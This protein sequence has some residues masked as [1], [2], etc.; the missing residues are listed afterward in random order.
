MRT[1]PIEVDGSRVTGGRERT[2]R[3]NQAALAESD[4]IGERLTRSRCQMEDHGMETRT[5]PD[6]VEV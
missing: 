2:G 1:F 3:R 5:G 4:V 6:A